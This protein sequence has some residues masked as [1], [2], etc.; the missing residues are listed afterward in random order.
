M[1]DREQI[2][3]SFAKLKAM[4]YDEVQT[5]GCKIPYEDFGRLAEEAG[6]EIVGT[7][8][9]FNKMV[10]TPEISIADHKALK[11]KN[12]GIGGLVFSKASEI[13][14]FIIK[15]NKVAEIIYNQGFKFTFHNHSREFAK[16]DNGKTAMDVLFEGLDPEK[17]SFVLDTYWAQLGGANPVEW[18][19]K[20]AGRIEI[21]PLKDY[22]VTV[23]SKPFYTE[24]GNGN[25]NFEKIIETAEKT[26]VKYLCVEQDLCPG[27][28]FE[29]LKISREY[30]GRFFEK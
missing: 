4:G 13:E 5:A 26:G 30:L 3:E 7:H 11:T 14:E 29:S 2:R 25:L 8:D 15:A 6:I 20:L 1:N 24:I 27:D 21:L 28:P 23:D 18:I 10:N 19:E 16:L 22:S 9:D 12:M 17:T